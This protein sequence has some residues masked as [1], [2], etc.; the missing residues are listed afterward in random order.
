MNGRRGVSTPAR[1]DKLAVMDDDLGAR[2]LLLV[3]M[4]AAGVLLIW[5]AHAAA[6][7]RIKRNP[8]AGIRTAATMESDQ[9]WL[10]AHV[11]AKPATVRAGIAAIVSGLAA[12][13]PLP[14]PVSAAVVVVGCAVMLAFV[15]HGARIG[16]RAARNATHDASGR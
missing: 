5:V 6:S 7:G 13:P 4:T 14:T 2:I 8:I 10:A 11:R 1:L 9:A 12:L 3:V 16:S 15:L